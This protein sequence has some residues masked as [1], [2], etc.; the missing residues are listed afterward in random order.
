[1]VEWDFDAR[2]ALA[3]RRARAEFTTYIRAECGEV[4][5]SSVELVLGELIGNV[6]R[7]APGPA[8]VRAWVDDRFKVT[9][10]V[11]D[12]GPG[13]IRPLVTSVDPLAESGRGLLIVELLSDE[14]IVHCVANRGCRVRA[15]LS[16][17]AAAC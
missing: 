7:Y 10:E 11:E 16:M 4:D 3:A 9:I 17:K 5:A 8:Y 1:M 15:R 6:V 2:D 12:R 13:F 14:F